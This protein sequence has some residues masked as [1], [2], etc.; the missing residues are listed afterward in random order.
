MITD[1][2]IY[3]GGGTTILNIFTQNTQNDTL[4]DDGTVNRLIE[5]CSQSKESLSTLYNMFKKSV[6]AV[7]YSITSDYQLAEDCVAETFIRLTQVRNFNSAKGD[8]RGFIHK[9][10]R[11]VALEIRRSHHKDIDNVYIS[12]YGESDNTIENSLWLNGLLANLS[13]KQRQIVV[14]RC[15]SELSFKEIAKIM[16]CPESTIK[17]RYRK[18]ISILQEKAGVDSEKRK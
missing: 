9:V 17:S 15:C 2:E 1:S 10:A 8:G 11:N 4:Q 3:K 14:M 18:A 5:N 16:K 7:A 6:F 12:N 13:D